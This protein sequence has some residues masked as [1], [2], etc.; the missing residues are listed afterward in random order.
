MKDWFPIFLS[1][2]FLGFLLLHLITSMAMDLK[3][4]GEIDCKFKQVW[5]RPR[6]LC[7]CTLCRWFGSS[8]R[9]GCLSPHRARNEI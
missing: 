9:P 8:S 5:Q 4:F 6:I 7:R 1:I 3:S 2:D